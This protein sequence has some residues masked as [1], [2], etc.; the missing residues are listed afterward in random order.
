MAFG[1]NS[2]ALSAV[3]SFRQL[4]GQFT[5][6][7]SG[8]KSGGGGIP[9]FVDMYRPTMNGIDVVRLVPGEYLQ[10]QI[11]GEG[12]DAKIV[13]VVMP[14]IKFVEHFDGTMQKGVTCSAGAFAHRRSLPITI[15]RRLHL[16]P[17]RKMGKRL[18]LHQERT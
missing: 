15:G 14:F 7:S 13:Q 17:Q 3:G 18:A 1:K 5:K 10:D 6:N 2:A 12:E 11:Q 4:S 9:Y 16:V 8:R